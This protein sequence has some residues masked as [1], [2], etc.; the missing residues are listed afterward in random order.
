MRMLIFLFA[1]CLNQLNAQKHTY[2]GPEVLDAGFADTFAQL[3]NYF[4]QNLR[5]P[6][7][8]AMRHVEGTVVVTFT[9]NADGTIARAK[10]RH[11]LGHGCDE[12]AL[13]LVQSMPRWQPATL[14]GRP[15]ACGK[16]VYVNFRI[17]RQTLSERL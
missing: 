17:N 7:A 14:N 12:E 2:A 11:G 9:V 16:T 13:R 8:A 3:S 5:Y 15:I 1:I 4:N 6:A 10:I